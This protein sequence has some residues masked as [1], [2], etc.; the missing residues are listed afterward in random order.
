MASL[1]MLRCSP[2]SQSAQNESNGIFLDFPFHFALLFFPYRFFTCVF[3]FPICG[4]FLVLNFFGFGV[5]ICFKE[6]KKKNTKL[7]V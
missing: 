6:R 5:F 7:V 1:H 3:W 2:V 4:L